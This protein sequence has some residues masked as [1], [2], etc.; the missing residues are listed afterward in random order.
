VSTTPV[1][2]NNVNVELV[3]EDSGEL[4][5]CDELSAISD[6]ADELMDDG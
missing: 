6:G 3:V 5:I 4:P 1:D 2:S